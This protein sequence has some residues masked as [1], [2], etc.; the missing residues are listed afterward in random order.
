M[1]ATGEV[2]A[3]GRNI[4]ESLLK[5]VRSLEI[6]THHIELPDLADITDDDLIQK[7]GSS[8][9]MIVCFYVS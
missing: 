7:V 6:G 8:T 2:M 4:E 5:A 9:S 1:K 3:I